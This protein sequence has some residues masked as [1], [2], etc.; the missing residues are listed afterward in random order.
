MDK[1]RKISGSL[2][3]IQGALICLIIFSVVG[4][5]PDM[6]KVN[7]LLVLSLGFVSIASGYSLLTKLSWMH[8]ASMT[9]AFLAF[10]AFPLGTALAVYYF[11]FYKTYVYAKT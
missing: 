8:K 7:V 3:L 1:H 4:N 2:F 11:W 9:A 5:N 10:F 6:S